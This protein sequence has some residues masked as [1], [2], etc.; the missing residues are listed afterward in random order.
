MSG[1]PLFFALLI[2]LFRS[3]LCS[4]CAARIAIANM[5]NQ[6]CKSCLP[7]CLLSLEEEILFC[8]NMHIYITVIRV[9]TSGLVSVE[10]GLVVLVS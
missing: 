1:Q 4:F 9:V 3:E 5:L 8:S 6:K 2:H 7:D 10:P